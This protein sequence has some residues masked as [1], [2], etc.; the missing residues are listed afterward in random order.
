MHRKSAIEGQHQ[1]SGHQS[2]DI[3][4]RT[5]STDP[6]QDAICIRQKVVCEQPAGLPGPCCAAATPG[7]ELW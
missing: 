6:K 7:A 3:G 1:R 2:T 5:D 4:Q